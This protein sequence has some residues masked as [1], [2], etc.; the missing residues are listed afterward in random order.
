MLWEFAYVYADMAPDMALQ[1]E[2]HS[3]K[4]VMEN[5][6]CKS[7]GTSFSKCDRGSKIDWMCRLHICK[8]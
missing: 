6:V 7:S 2:V 3:I 4:T 5:F 8:E 1:V